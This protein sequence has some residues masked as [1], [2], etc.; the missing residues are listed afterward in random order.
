MRI[1]ISKSNFITASLDLALQDSTDA[2]KAVPLSSFWPLHLVVAWSKRRLVNAFY[3]LYAGSCFQPRK[4][5]R[6]VAPRVMS[7]CRSFGK[8]GCCAP[9]V[10]PLRTPHRKDSLLLLPE[11][12]S[13]SAVVAS[14]TQHCEQMRQMTS[15][16]QVLLAR[17]DGAEKE[18][19]SRREQN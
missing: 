15:V 2:L 13:G 11:W 17:L 16:D 7:D 4:Q 5:Y 18:R 3:C 12:T 6:L 9:L 14:M 10:K 8:A 19:Q 1:P